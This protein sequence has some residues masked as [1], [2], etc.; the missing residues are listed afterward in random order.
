MDRVIDPIADGGGAGLREAAGFVE[1]N[2][3]LL[4]EDALVLDNPPPS[5]VD[6]HVAF[7]PDHGHHGI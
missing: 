4:A 3:S 2:S 7:A 5:R 6:S 1:R